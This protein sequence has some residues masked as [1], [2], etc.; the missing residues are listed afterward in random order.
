MK[1]YVAKPAEVTHNWYVIDATKLNLGRLAANVAKLLRGKH[2]PEFTPHVD[3]GDHVV[4]IN[5]EKVPYTGASKGDELYQW[6]TGYPGGIKAIKRKDLVKK[7]PT[8][9]IEKTVKGMLPRGPL[10]RD[11]FR[12]LHVYAG[13]EHPHQAQQ[14]VV[15]ED[16][17]KMLG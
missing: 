10:G 1:T 11:V 17:E 4:I 8:R 3:T 12:K 13:A 16:L 5:A 6:H 7:H 9:V 14:P 15:I 2:K